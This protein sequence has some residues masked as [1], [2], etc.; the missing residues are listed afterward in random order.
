MTQWLAMLAGQDLGQGGTLQFHQEPWLVLVAGA[1]AVLSVVALSAGE[2]T[3]RQRVLEIGAVTLAWVGL[4]FALAAPTWV[5]E[6]GRREP[7]RVA[8][9]IDSSAS[10]GVKENGVSRAASVEAIVASMGTSNVDVYH[11]GDRVQPGFPLAYDQPVTDIGTAFASLAER[12]AGETLES[13][14]LITDGLDRGVLRQSYENGVPSPISDLPGPLTVYQ[15]GEQGALR[16]VAVRWVDGGGFAYVHSPFTLTASIRGVGYESTQI[17]VELARDGSVVSTGQALIDE[18]GDAEVTFEVTPDR[19]GRFTY[20]VSVPD[21]EDDAVPANNLLPVVVRVVRDKLRVLQVA[22]APS[23]DVKFLRRFLKGDPSVDLVSF[24]I[25]R[26]REDFRRRFKDSE[27]SLIQFPTEQLFTEDLNTF[28]LVVLQN[29]DHEPYFRA[30]STELLENLRRYVVDEGHGLVMVGGDRSFSLGAYGGTPV[31]DVLPV[32][33]SMSMVEP[34]FDPFRPSLTEAGER[35]PVT[36]LVSDPVENAAWWERLH[37]LDGANRGLELA[38]SSTALLTHPTARTTSGQALP[39]LSVREVG[40][41]RTMALAVDTSWR[42]SLSEAAEGRGNQA[43]LR[44]WK[45]AMRWLIRD[46]STE[47]LS[48]ETSRENYA[49]G[50]NIRAVVMVR[51]PEFGPLADVDVDLTIKMGGREETQTARSGPDGEAVFELSAERSGA[52]RLVADARLDP[53]T[54][55]TAETVFGVTTRDPELDEVVPDTAFLS[56]LVGELG[57]RRYGPGELG[58]RLQDDAAGRTVFDR[59]ETP[60]W[61]SPWLITWILTFAGLAWWIR[62]RAGLR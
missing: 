29:F 38:P 24:F 5:E 52:H 61:R 51:N 20:T 14:V 16:D 30:M 11:F 45:G 32:S 42:W 49:V 40:A 9:L 41:G 44:F 18:Q 10:M 21:Y 56:W 2:R 34:T 27:L 50:D 4:L 37:T 31:G 53:S 43:Y 54:S 13:V 8:V 7:G 28:D 46:P 36:R 19:A 35:H 1:A 57:G 39:I 3:P 25:L 47:R 15:V 58:P 59:K 33:V 12:V 62:R 26:T 55:L 60:L 48:V 22:G 23:W 6:S 17:P